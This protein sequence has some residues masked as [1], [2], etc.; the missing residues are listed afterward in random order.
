ML[1]WEDWRGALG[2]DG[3]RVALETGKCWE[4]PGGAICSPLGLLGKGGIGDV[5]MQRMKSSLV[6]A[7]GG[8]SAHPWRCPW[9]WTSIATSTYEFLSAFRLEYLPN[10]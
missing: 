2:A 3:K 5:G 6:R 9:P 8:L 4:D 1:R 7:R 10:A